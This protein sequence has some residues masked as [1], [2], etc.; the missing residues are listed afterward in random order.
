M[1]NLPKLTPYWWMP[2]ESE[3][4]SFRL[5]PLTQPQMVEVE[6]LYK[7]GKVT[8]KAAY[9]AGTLGIIGV[10]GARH[11]ETGAPAVPPSCFEWLNRAWVRTCGYRLIAE[12]MGVDWDA[13][14]KRLETDEATH[15]TPEETEQGN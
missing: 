8:D 15:Q 2:D 1:A 4:V 10:R 11:P 3:G 13:M 6:D 12:D 5:R 14:M 9:L 7:D